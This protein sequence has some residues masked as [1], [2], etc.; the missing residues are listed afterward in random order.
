MRNLVCEDHAVRELSLPH[1]DEAGGGATTRVD[2]LCVAD[3]R[4]YLATASAGI[5][6]VDPDAVGGN[7]G[8]E[9]SVQLLPP[10]PLP[11]P[12]S[13]L[14]AP[15]LPPPLQQQQPPAVAAL[16]AQPELGGLF[17]GLAAGGELLVL[18]PGEPGGGRGGHRAAQVDVDVE[19]VGALAGAGAGGLAAA[20]WSPDGALLAAATR[21]GRLLLLTGAP[22]WEVLA[23]VDIPRPD[24][25]GGGSPPPLL[26]VDITWRGDG[27][28]FATSSAPVGGT[29]GGGGGGGG[30]GGIGV[31]SAAAAARAL[32]IW[33]REEEEPEPGGCTALGAGGNHDGGG[34][35]GGAGGDEDGGPRGGGGGA[36]GGRYCVLHASGEEA[37]GLTGAV[38]WQPNCR[39]LFAAQV[40]P[41]GHDVDAVAPAK[42]KLAAVP[43][44]LRTL[45]AAAVAA[46][47]AG[48]RAPRQASIASAPRTGDEEP[49]PRDQ[50]WLRVALFE[51]NGLKHGG[52]EVVPPNRGA[53]A[54]AAPPAAANAANA[55]ATPPPSTDDRPLLPPPPRISSMAWSPDSELLAVVVEP[56]AG[57]DRPW[58]VQ[59]W[60]R[61]NWHWYLKHELRLGG[62]GRGR[63][64]AQG[65]G[66]AGA[67]AAASGPPA[68]ALGGR[69]LACWDEAAPPGVA[70]VLHVVS[71]GGRAAPA[72][73]HDR[74]RLAWAPCASPL[75]TLL[76]VDGADVLVTPARVSLVPPPMCAVRLRCGAPVCALAVSGPA[77]E[78]PD[79][80]A[81]EEEEEDEEEEEGEDGE[82]QAGELRRQ[83]RVWG[84]PKHAGVPR[85]GRERV[86]AVLAGGRLAVAAA[87]EDDL[88]AE[89]LDEARQ[90]QREG[91]APA[92]A[93]AATPGRD[94][95]G[96][97]LLL[98]AEAVGE[99]G[100]LL[101]G[102]RPVR[103]AAWVSPTR[104]LLVAAPTLPADGGPGRGDV[105]VEV[106]LRA[107]GGLAAAAVAA[108]GEDGGGGGGGN[109]GGGDNDTP[110]P[111][112][113]WRELGACRAGMSVLAAASAPSGAGGALVQL[114]DGRLARY[115]PCSLPPPPLPPPPLSSTAAADAAVGGSGR[116]QLL[117]ADASFPAPCSV[118][119]PLPPNAG[120]GGGGGGDWRCPPAVGLDLSSGRLFLGPRVLASDATS[121]AV[122]SDGP[123][124]AALLW[125]CRGDVL[126][127]ALLPVLVRRLRGGGGMGGAGGGGAGGGGRGGGAVAAAGDAAVA[128]ARRPQPPAAG[129]AEAG[130][131][132]PRMAPVSRRGDEHILRGA[133]RQAI[134]TAM[135]PDASRLV[136]AT[137]A[138]AYG[139][140]RQRRAREQEEA[141]RAWW[142]RAPPARRSA[143]TLDARPVEQGARLVCA[144]CG[145]ERCVL[146]MPRGNLEAVAP[147]L[148]A[149]AAAARAV[150]AGLW[151]EAWDLVGEH[152]LDP[153]LLADCCGR[154]P[155]VAA[156]AADAAA[157]APCSA[158]SSLLVADADAFVAA[159]RSAADLCDFVHA[160]RPGSTLRDAD[161]G[162]PSNAD[163]GDDGDVDPALKATTGAARV[164]ATTAAEA[165]ATAVAGLYAALPETAGVPD[166]VGARPAPGS[167]EAN[168][169]TLVCTAIR[170]AVLRR[171]RA[172]AAAATGGGGAGTDG[173]APA[174]AAAAAALPPLGAGDLRVVVATYARSDPPDLEAAL[175]AVKDAKEAA[176]AAEAAAAAAAAAAPSSSLSSSSLDAAAEAIRHLLLHVDADRLYEAAIGLY[177]LPL[178]FA[179][180]SEAQ[181]DPGAALEELRALGRQRDPHLR[182]AGVDARLGRHDRAAAHLLAAGPAHFGRAL[183]LAKEHGFLR[184]FVG[185]V[186]A[187]RVH[188][189]EEGEPAARSAPACD[190]DNNNSAAGKQPSRLPTRD[191]RQSQ[192]NEALEAYGEQ[193]MASGRAEDAALAFAAA[194]RPGRS[195][196]AY[197]AAGAWRAALACAAGPAR[198]PADAV[199]AL[200]G[201]LVDD[202]CASG[203]AAAGAEVALDALGDADRAAQLFSGAGEWRRA[204]HVCHGRRRAD[205]VETVVAPHAAAAAAALLE[206]A[207]ESEARVRKYAA[208][209]AEVRA[210]REQ[211]GAALARLAGGGGEDGGV[212]EDGGD[213]GDGDR[214]GDFDAASEAPSVLSG[215]SAYTDASTAGFGA[216]GG[217]S[218]SSGSASSSFGG[219]GGGGGAPSTLGGR[220]G[221]GKNSAAKKAARDAR[222][223][224]RRGA[225][226]RIRQGGFLEEV[227]LCSL[228][229]SLAPKPHA[230]LA[231]GALAEALVLLGHERD[232]A[233]VQRAVASW[234]RAAAGARA[235]VAARPPPEDELRQAEP[236]VRKAVEGAVFG[237]G[238]GEAVAWKWDVLRD[239]DAV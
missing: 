181:R 152:R 58:A 207:R 144:P 115:L 103:L 214:D 56:A 100:A 198:W 234:Q 154:A 138:S 51:R 159:A 98:A 162:A 183:G 191:A 37:P 167:P 220:P 73:R 156:A 17:V 116:L 110:P 9:W 180:A 227:S 161:E 130:A 94:R 146:Q 204:L 114:A 149:L 53:A 165:E 57:S 218:S 52:F 145:G 59:V 215:F 93:A 178:A 157:A 16:C 79:D 19:E 166:L 3:D 45:P 95:F 71:S 239:V 42:G 65:N 18:R 176:L 203:Q 172:A 237:A 197:R 4:L 184:R 77:L 213:G 127:L 147:R 67:A 225:Q 112:L 229:L 81:E 125:T 33:A 224:S 201:E 31:T 23:E 124:G 169:V 202:L 60:H 27:R 173:G 236:E 209:L 69:V 188:G 22:G 39:H 196:D 8:V 232:A 211:M 14:D 129:A 135:R 113:T 34:G 36:A 137:M 119:I 226:G 223:A 44:P 35:A 72:V 78:D 64:R 104:L 87:V 217:G 175:L 6:C 228:V 111:R 91:R 101:A 2:A 7:G 177:D 102:G 80:E 40:V 128:T 1:G 219:G 49:G 10:P 131:A 62:G 134:A 43:A 13:P 185:M 21:A 25:A 182:R 48:G 75:G 206:E 190:N 99:A 151:R 83:R 46:A 32:H 189:E 38:A 61:R 179:V 187:Q 212:D 108:N 126:R 41:A 55:A 123:G 192:L 84:G 15:A 89:T 221:G 148:L 136:G 47:V 29:R 118:M 139:P 199:R 170:E 122:R 222:K 210:R 86:A 120:G 168:K 24:G 150:R 233:R 68:P 50:P 163:D 200:A 132:R 54:G 195:V 117:G 76:A 92:A 160:L 158:S 141:E 171:A 74:L 109:G 231:A 205:L 186:R 107:G 235:E 153:N 121:V 88:W 63:G 155:R 20:A 174:A 105:L 82:E 164:A 106:Q 66:G 30:S 208:R 11:P 70:G 230:L 12:P 90:D 142:S 5:H 96:A 194:A 238:G 140:S 216:G 28:F 97:P 85:A 133:L 193:L 26:D 143:E